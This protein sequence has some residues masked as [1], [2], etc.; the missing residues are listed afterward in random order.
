[1]DRFFSANFADSPGVKLEGD[2][3]H[4]LVHV[5][6]AKPGDPVELFDGEGRSAAAAIERIT[7]REAVLRLTGEIQRDA[8]DAVRVVLAVACPK[9]DRL[10]W[11]VEK[12]TELGV[13][14]FI[15]LSCERSVVE[16]REN[17]LAKLEAT[18]LAACK[19]SRRNTLMRIG[20]A[21]SLEQFLAAGSAERRVTLFADP[22]GDPVRDALDN[23]SFS[24]CSTIAVTIGPEGGFT[25][26]ELEE[27][28]GAGAVPV[29]LGLTIL[30][31]ET[32]AIAFAA[33]V[34]AFAI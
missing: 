21:A 3:F 22:A 26:R 20:E 14:E 24:Q 4:H 28:R 9:G 23:I 16:P 2:E 17:R 13:A 32:A 29:R 31:V 19:Q 15:P 12:A 34:R 6:R 7:K 10:K 33:A 27:A 1:M 8:P 5:L 11:L 18:V 25:P 30:R